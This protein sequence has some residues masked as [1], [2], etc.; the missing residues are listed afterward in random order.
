M[1]SPSP[2][3]HGDMTER[4]AMAQKLRE[5]REYLGLSQDEVSTHLGIP[6]TALSNIENGQRKVDAIELH[7]LSVLY[8][9]P[10]NHFTGGNDHDFVPEEVKHLARTASELSKND[11]KELSRFAE[12]LKSRST[13]KEE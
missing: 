3:N 11:L 8:N 1:N 6:R 2:A 13:L 4:L 9:R 5:C 12:F 10:I 7:K